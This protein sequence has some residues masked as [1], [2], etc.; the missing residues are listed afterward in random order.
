MGRETELR[1]DLK[2]QLA[3][4]AK[5]RGIALPCRTGEAF[6]LLMQ[7]GYRVDRVKLNWYEKSGRFYAPRASGKQ[8]YQWGL[9]T[10]VSCAVELEADRSWRAGARLAN[11]TARELDQDAKI[12]ATDPHGLWSKNGD[13][14]ERLSR[15]SLAELLHGI[16]DE[17]DAGRL[18]ALETEL[19]RRLP[20][21]TPD[22][23]FFLLRVIGGLDDLDGR[24]TV[25]DLLLHEL[26]P[27]GLLKPEA[28]AEGGRIDVRV[29]LLKPEGG[30]DAE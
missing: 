16:T 19:N 25:V 13:L 24:R 11:K 7:L 14:W 6:E 3:E 10:L 18:Y 22:R 20:E 29:R 12:L 4:L 2:E 28:G 17:A 26:E 15:A 1:A 21:D 23:V 30:A 9:D 27:L 5:A 8:V